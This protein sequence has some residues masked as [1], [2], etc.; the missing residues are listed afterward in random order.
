MGDSRSETD[1]K[2]NPLNPNNC[3]NNCQTDERQVINNPRQTETM[4]AEDNCRG[5]YPRQIDDSDRE[6]LTDRQKTS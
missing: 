1:N 6:Q 5:S 3:Q 4:R 2:D